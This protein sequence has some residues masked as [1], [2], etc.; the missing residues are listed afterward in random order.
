MCPFPCFN[1]NI[2]F[3]EKSVFCD[4]SQYFLVALIVLQN[5]GNRFIHKM[6]SLKR[7]PYCLSACVLHYVISH[8]PELGQIITE[9][10]YSTEYQNSTEIPESRNYTRGARSEHGENWDGLV[11]GVNLLVCVSGQTFISMSVLLPP[12]VSPE[13]VNNLNAGPTCYRSVAG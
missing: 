7:S 2:L 4:L 12:Q 10:Q 1:V 6:H 9:S 11:N 3:Q 13:I 5:E 8:D